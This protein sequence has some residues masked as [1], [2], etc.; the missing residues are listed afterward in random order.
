ME[1]TAGRHSGPLVSALSRHALSF[2]RGDLFTEPLATRGASDSAPKDAGFVTAS[3]LQFQVSGGPTGKGLVSAPFTTCAGDNVA[4]IPPSHSRS[5]SRR[6]TLPQIASGSTPEN[7]AAQAR[8][9]VLKSNCGWPPPS[10]SRVT[11]APHREWPYKERS[12][13]SPTDGSS[14]ARFQTTHSLARALQ[15]ND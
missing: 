11:F 3:H 8:G 9:E 7:Y 14:I 6:P 5:H 12:H 2:N 10:H 4:S 15:A 13:P 1:D